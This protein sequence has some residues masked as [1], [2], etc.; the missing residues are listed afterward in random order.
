MIDKRY[1]REA[2]DVQSACNL[3]GVVFAFERAMTA[4]CEEA[5]RL[6]KG[7]DW[8]NTHPIAVL[9]ATQI[10]HLT[11]TSILAEQDVYRKAYEAVVAELEKE[12]EADRCPHGMFYTGAGACPACGG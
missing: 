3:S 1:W 7:T 6:G 9:F 2:M 5:Q 8:K 11:K 10:G 12:D 4:I